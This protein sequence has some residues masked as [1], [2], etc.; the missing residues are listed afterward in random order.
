VEQLV[1][2]SVMTEV[3]IL[4]ISGLLAYSVCQRSLDEASVTASRQL[5][6]GEYD[7]I[8]EELKEL[9]ERH[10]GKAEPQT[11]HTA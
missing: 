11:K 2:Y 1:G 4:M 9:D 3:D 10:D 6:G 5:V 8:E 7:Q